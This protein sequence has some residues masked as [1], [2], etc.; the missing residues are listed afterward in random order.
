MI[1]KTEATLSPGNSR[2]FVG[3][4]IFRCKKEGE[5]SKSL[6]SS[7]G[8]FAN[9]FHRFSISTRTEQTSH[10]SQR[11]VNKIYPL[12]VLPVKEVL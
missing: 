5:A 11:K 10:A 9:E 4:N 1:F 8:H 2:R 12:S 7:F 6:Y 3:V